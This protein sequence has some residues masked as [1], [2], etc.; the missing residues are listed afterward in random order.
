M[1]KF[2]AITNNIS[3]RKNNEM[4]MTTRMIQIMIKTKLINTLITINND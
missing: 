4:F 3:N 1:K 2:M